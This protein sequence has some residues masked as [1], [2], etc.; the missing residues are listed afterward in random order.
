MFRQSNSLANFVV[1]TA[2]I[3]S[4]IVVVRELRQPFPNQN[5]TAAELVVTNP[6]TMTPVVATDIPVD[7]EP[8]LAPVKRNVRVSAATQRLLEMSQ[9]QQ[10][11]DAAQVE[12]TDATDD[13]DTTDLVDPVTD[14]SDVDSTETGSPESPVQTVVTESVEPATA[15]TQESPVATTDEVTV[16]EVDAA[17]D[18]LAV[19]VETDVVAGTTIVDEPA[20]ATVTDLVIRNPSTTG[21]RAVVLIDRRYHTIQPGDEVTLPGD[22]PFSVRFQIGNRSLSAEQMLTPG[23]YDLGRNNYGWTVASVPAK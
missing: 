1:L 13:V 2:L 3:I 19:D 8:V 9:R 22:G 14:S 6:I 23:Q 4:G 11:T 18:E 15:T 7:A 5:E 12:S 21:Q 17:A 16:A 10:A 20:T